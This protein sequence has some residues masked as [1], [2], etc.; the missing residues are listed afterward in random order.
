MYFYYVS[1]FQ[2]GMQ[3]FKLLYSS[4]LEFNFKLSNE[5][6]FCNRPVSILLSSYTNI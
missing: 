5:T 1:I 2:V 6:V 3:I 4:V